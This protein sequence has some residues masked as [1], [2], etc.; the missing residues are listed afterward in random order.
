MT[1]SK[2]KPN[3]YSST[4]HAYAPES[5]ASLQVPGWE[6][7]VSTITATKYELFLLTI[8]TVLVQ[9]FKE[10][11]PPHARDRLRRSRH[12]LV[13]ENPIRGKSR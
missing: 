3:T 6:S 4:K 13:R 11:D 9:Q 10:A 8:T 12:A 2:S 1:L 7:L 5:L